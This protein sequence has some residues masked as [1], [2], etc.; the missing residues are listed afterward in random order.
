MFEPKQIAIIGATASGKS[1]V[2]IKMA[3]KYNLVISIY[4]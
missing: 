4:I 1:N 3:K 2:A